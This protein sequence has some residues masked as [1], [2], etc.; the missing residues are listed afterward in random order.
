MKNTNRISIVSRSSPAPV[1]NGKRARPKR[2]STR[3]AS[4]LRRARRRFESL[5]LRCRAADGRGVRRDA[6]GRACSP[7]VFAPLAAWLTLVVALLAFQITL[8]AAENP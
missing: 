7:Y 5:V 3:R 6:R 8:A 4:N 2:S 1:E